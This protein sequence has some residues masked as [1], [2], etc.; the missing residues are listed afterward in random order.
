MILGAAAGRGPS[1]LRLLAACLGLGCLVILL[2]LLRPGLLVRLDL[3][4]YDRLAAA[5]PVRPPSGRVTLVE[6][7][8]RS[9]AE[10]G[11]WPW[12]RDRVAALLDR[13]R[14]LGAV[15]VGL[16][17]LFPEPDAAGEVSAGPGRPP[18]ASS[19]GPPALSTRDSALAAALARGPFVT[20]Y[21]F[22]FDR[23]VDRPCPLRSIGVARASAAGAVTAVPRAAGVLCSLV[24]FESAAASS[25]FLNA[26]PDVD[27]TLR[28]MPQLV[29]FG[30]ELYPSLAL[31]TVRKG[32]AVQ[33]LAVA[34]PA[35]G[36]PALRLDDR[37]IPLAADGSLLVRFRG[38]AGTFPRLSAVDV[39]EDRAPAGALAG[40]LAFVGVSA[41]GLGDMVAT[42]LG[43][44]LAGVEVQATVADNLLRGDFLRRPPGATVAELG[45]ILAAA[46]GVAVGIV[47]LG[48]RWTVPL[49]LGVGLLLWLGTGWLID[50]RGWFVSPL[51]PTLA[52]AGALGLAGVQ[53]LV[54]ERARADQST[55]QL[56]TA[57]EMVLHALTSLT[58]TR[59][60]ETG[61]HL[62]RTS[63]YARVLCEALASHPKFRVFFTPETIDLVARLAPIHDIGK[64][65]VADR[66]LRKPGPLSDDERDEM[67][68]HPIYGRDVIVR[69]EERVGVRDDLLLTLAKQIV[70]SH[71]ER[72]DGRGYPEG[73]RGEAIPIAGRVVALVD[74][75]DA[76][77]SA[78]VYKSTLPHAEVVRAIVAERGTHFD[79]DMVDTFLRI[80]EEWRRI[81]VEF[82]DEHDV[83]HPSAAGHRHEPV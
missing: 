17:L 31:A 52:L 72:W 82:A 67:E 49:S 63:R 14:S 33:R 12:P 68:R 83:D 74:C 30:G 45:L 64:V 62:V 78:R 37:E 3:A 10:A 8:E 41:L 75:Y 48:W 20:G 44:F 50:A 79:P 18:P 43:V 4:V 80:Q 61:A 22:T 34:E 58:E 81:A 77:A 47:G 66:T 9:L 15:A 16:D 42:P 28:R 32:L 6:I 13:V 56:R 76:L 29:E 19:G 60:V 36:W 2:H 55:R 38:P 23:A 21:A 70:Y 1:P 24:Q 46:V 73:L 65:G 39:L 71:H 53:R 27:G 7:D 5:S 57:R 54:A 35:S 40:R 51:F 59:D 69:T 11:R 25:G 26:S